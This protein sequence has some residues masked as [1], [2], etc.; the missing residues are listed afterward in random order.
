MPKYISLKQTEVDKNVMYLKGIDNVVKTCMDLEILNSYT[1][2]NVSFLMLQL[3][4]H[5]C[6]HPCIFQPSFALPIFPNLDV[7]FC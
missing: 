4:L 7:I 5:P 1:N 3:T 6:I 2:L